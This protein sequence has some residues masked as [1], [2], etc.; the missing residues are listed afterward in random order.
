MKS[1]YLLP[2]SL[3]SYAQIRMLLL[4]HKLNFVVC[5]LPG[6]HQNRGVY[7][8]SNLPDDLGIQYQTY[9][10]DQIISEVLLL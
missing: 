9:H 1:L 4:A 6:P 10:K 2:S 7:V 3:S 8:H 5:V